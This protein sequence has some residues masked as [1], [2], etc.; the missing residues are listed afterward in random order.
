MSE[1]ILGQHQEDANAPEL[2]LRHGIQKHLSA[3]AELVRLRFQ[4]FGTPEGST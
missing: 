3:H 1:R 2:V 4:K